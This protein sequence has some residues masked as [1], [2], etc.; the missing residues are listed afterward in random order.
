MV[1]VKRTSLLFGIVY[2][3]L[4]FHERA[5]PEYFFAGAMMVLGVFLIA[6]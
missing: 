6:A 4:L 1:A 5:R 3:V 2:S